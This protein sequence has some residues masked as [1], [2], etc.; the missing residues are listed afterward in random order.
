M[1]QPLQILLVEDA[2]LDAELTLGTLAEGGVRVE[3]VRVETEE[4]FRRELVRPEVGLILSDFSLPSFTGMDAMRIAHQVRP[5]LP[6]IFVSGAL[7]EASV[8]SHHPR[9]G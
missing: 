3:A 9:G 7:G 5:E 1:N 8:T 2:P 4:Q 6:F